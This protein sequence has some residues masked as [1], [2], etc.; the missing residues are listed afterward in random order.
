MKQISAKI[1]PVSRDRENSS[2]TTQNICYHTVT[3]TIRGDDFTMII[4]G[5]ATSKISTMTEVII[6]QTLANINN[7][8]DMLNIL[9]G[10]S[11]QSVPLLHL[12]ILT[13]YRSVIAE[14][15]NFLTT[16]ITL[17]RNMIRP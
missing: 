11:L 6:S 1:Y 7:F 9:K 4:T 16:V 17:V 14:R 3:N 5:S 13:T 2:T 8:C 12:K 15:T 10:N